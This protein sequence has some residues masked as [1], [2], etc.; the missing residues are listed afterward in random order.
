MVEVVK[1]LQRIQRGSSIN[2][3]APIKLS[4][5][6]SHES[7]IRP[8]FSDEADSQQKH[9]SGNESAKKLAKVCASLSLSLLLTLVQ[10]GSSPSLPMPPFLKRMSSSEIKHKDKDK[11][12]DEPFPGIRLITEREQPSNSSSTTGS[13]VNSPAKARRD[14]GSPV[15]RPLDRRSRQRDSAREKGQEREGLRFQPTLAVLRVT[16]DWEDLKAGQ[17]V[18]V[19]AFDGGWAQVREEKGLI[20]RE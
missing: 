15:V 4:R 6:N 14:R 19:T 9:H 5:N 10:A 12:K 18:K 8:R 1:I 11:D 16:E 20:E 13:N 17:E 7:L 3:Q 2:L